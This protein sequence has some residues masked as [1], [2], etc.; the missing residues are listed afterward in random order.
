MERSM[1]AAAQ[2]PTEPAGPSGL[3]HPPC[4]PGSSRAARWAEGARTAL[5][6]IS[7]AEPVYGIAG[8]IFEKDL[9]VS[10]RRRRNYILRFVYFILL[11][12]IVSMVWLSMV[13]APSFGSGGPATYAYSMAKAGATLT[14]VILWFQFIILPFIAVVML[15]TSISDEVRHRTLGVLLT[16]PI[17]SVHIVLGKFLG[18]M[19]QLG[20]LLAISVPIL[21]VVRVLGGVTGEFVIAGTCITLVTTMLAGSLSLFFSVGG[22]AIP[23]VVL[24]CLGA[25]LVLY[26]LLPLACFYTLGTAGAVDLAWITNP[27]MMLETLTESVVAQSPLAATVSWTSHCVVMLVM[28]WIILGISTLRVR[29]TALRQLVGDEGSWW[30]RRTSSV[31]RIHR[32]YGSPVAWKESRVRVFR[33]RIQSILSSVALLGILCATYGFV[34]QVEFDKPFTHVTYVIILIIYG[35]LYT[36]IVTST[37]VTSEKEAETWPILLITPLSNAAIVF[38]KAVGAMRRALP[39][40]LPLAFHL[41]LFT[42]LGYLH[43]VVLPLMTVIVLGLVAMLTGSGLL[44]GVLFRRT[45][46][47]AI[48]NFLLGVFIWVVLPMMGGFALAMLMFI[49]PRWFGASLVLLHPAVQAGLVLSQTAGTTFAGRGLMEI[50]FDMPDAANAFGVIGMTGA[51]VVLAGAHVLIGWL[52]ARAAAT[53]VRKGLA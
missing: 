13:V 52:F 11:A 27:Y 22:R 6:W 20:L 38:G 9:R 19:V 16:A 5:G 24:K 35:V 1:T 14:A 12:W 39:G 46:A 36:S 8:P 43:P 26:L 49:M 47:A 34:G 50:R 10:G 40:W 32:V 18:K 37:S 7:W 4:C 15:C 2:K 45:V 3:P 44:F 33:G 17:N 25:M 23:L 41:L 51:V 21:I 42:V 31:G 30:R 28:T 29:R 48:S 53:R